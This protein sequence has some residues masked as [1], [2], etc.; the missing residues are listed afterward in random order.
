MELQ[1]ITDS[2]DERYTKSTLQK[3]NRIDTAVEDN[4]IRVKSNV[5]KSERKRRTPRSFNIFSHEIGVSTVS[6]LSK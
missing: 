2:N 1:T 5:R 6:K 3:S 4:P